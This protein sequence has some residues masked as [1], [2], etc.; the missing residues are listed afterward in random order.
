MVKPGKTAPSS[1]VEVA[2]DGETGKVVGWEPVEQS[3]FSNYFD[4]ALADLVGPYEIDPDEGTYE[5]IGPRVNGNPEGKEF[6]ELVA[7]QYAEKISCFVGGFDII[8]EQLIELKIGR[9]VEGIVFHHP[10]GRMAKIKGR[11]FQFGSAGGDRHPAS[12][13]IDRTSP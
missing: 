2:R 10:D 11:D 7:H 8:R 3:A 6:H 4:E 1:F 5:L 12:A 13:A 9:G